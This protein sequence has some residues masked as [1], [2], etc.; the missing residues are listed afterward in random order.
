MSDI[1]T[2]KMLQAYFQDSPATSFLTGFFDARPENFYN[3]EE[4]EIDIERDDEDIA[5]AIT[6]LS[7]G[8]NINSSDLYTNKS[9]KPPILKE[10]A[11]LN[12]FDLI[13]RMAGKN[14]FE[15]FDFQA[16]A[17]VRAFKNFRLVEKKVRRTVELQSSQVLQTGLVDL[18]N[19]AG[20][21]LYTIDYKPK[22]THFPTVAIAW[23]NAATAVPINDIDSL[24]QL[25]RADGKTDPTDLIMGDT[26]WLE[27]I[28]TDQIKEHINF[29]RAN[30]IAI[31]PIMV[32]R[33]ATF[34]GEISVGNYV[35]KIWT[36]SGGYKDP[37]TGNHTKFVDPGKVIMTSEAGR[38]DAT[39]GAI[40][41]IAPPDS[42]VLPFLPS[43]MSDAD[44]RID[45]FTNAWLTP[46]GEQ[47]MTGVGARPLMIPTAI[48]TY[49]CMTT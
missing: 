37:Q 26:A 38:L 23:S 30:L 19:S 25:I 21:T 43:R 47:L 31:Q 5:I 7:T 44:M 46:D 13:K 4:I 3:S 8:Y 36:Y 17:T 39:F 35:Y 49:G 9:F 12:A 27:F 6:D 10:A 29:R 40:P 34:Q 28:A 45:L 32:G 14:P 48:D 16:N 2:H 15:D 24:A 33:G 18:K 22:A 41:R 11:A 42:R 1:G 20:V